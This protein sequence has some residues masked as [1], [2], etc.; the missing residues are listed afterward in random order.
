MGKWS[1]LS[2]KCASVQTKFHCPKHIISLWLD[3]QCQQGPLFQAHVFSHTQLHTLI[4]AFKNKKIDLSIMQPNPS[5]FKENNRSKE[6]L[7]NWAR[8]CG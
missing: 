8:A 2:L 3:Y 4:Y 5:D 7:R 1:L 6:K